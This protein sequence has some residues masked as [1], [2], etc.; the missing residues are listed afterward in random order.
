MNGTGRATASGRSPECCCLWS[1]S[2]G[3]VE[4]DGVAEVLELGDQAPGVGLGAAGLV[5]PAGAE[6]VV[7]L[8]AHEHPVGADQD[9]VGDG[10]GGAVVAAPPLPSPTPSWSAPTGCSCATSPTTTSAPAGSTSPAAPRPTPGAWSPNSNTSATPSSSTR[11]ADSDHRQQHSGLRPDAVARPVP[12]IH[13][14]VWVTVCGQ[15]VQNSKAA[16]SGQVECRSGGTSTCS[17]GTP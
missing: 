3:R 13:G 7:G 17:T 8:V 12:F 15:A 10:N 11:P 1:L 5:E 4:D 16:G 6:V 9:G 2:A 14:S